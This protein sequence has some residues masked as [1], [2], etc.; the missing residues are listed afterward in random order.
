MSD[1]KPIRGT[2]TMGFNIPVYIYPTNRLRWNGR[3]LEQAWEGTDESVTW[4]AIPDKEESD[5]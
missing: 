2:V 4:K 1:E 3:I 5:D